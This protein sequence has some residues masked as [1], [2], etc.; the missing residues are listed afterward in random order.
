MSKILIGEEARA[1]L[2]KGANH[3]ADT[4]KVTLGPQGKNVII[5]K[6]GNIHTTKDGV[7][8][9][10]SIYLADNAEN[11]GAQMVKEVASKTGDVAGD[12]TTTSVVLAQ[13]IM[14]QW[15]EM[16]NSGQIVHINKFKKGIE[17]ALKI[18]L[19]TIKEKAVKIESVE[20]LQLIA[21]ISS[22]GDSEIAK[23]VAETIWRIGVDGLITIEDSKNF[24]THVVN[25]DGMQIDRG[26]IHPGFITNHGNLTCELTKP[27]I[28]LTDKKLSFLKDLMPVLKDL[29]A[30][31]SPYKSLLII[32]EDMD[33]EALATLI[34]NNEKGTIPCCVIKRP[35][36]GTLSD[37]IMGDIATLTDGTY[38]SDAYG[39]SMKEANGSTCGK[40]DK[41]IV[42]RN[43]TII[44]GGKGKPV[45]IEKRISEIK[46][47]LSS[48]DNQ[49]TEIFA[50]RRLARITSKVAIFNVAGISEM[51]K[52][53]KKDRIDDAIC[54]AKAALEE[55]YVSGM[56][57]I[58]IEA[59]RNIREYIDN[60][61]DID[62]EEL[63]MQLIE[64]AILVPTCSIY[65]N[66]DVNIDV[67]VI[68][69]FNYNS[70]KSLYNISYVSLKEEGI[71]DP[72]KV[73]RVAIENAISI[74]LLFLSTDG[75]V[76]D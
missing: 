13:A 57:S 3:L 75:I 53:E 69:E 28:V 51:E 68:K 71:I 17:K 5:S 64:N 67:K 15:T 65:R 4:V 60:V 35:E 31:N 48:S 23:L 34:Y 49:T 26:V 2:I 21:E 16:K 66:A 73:T 1:S 10:K 58:Y 62:S 27:L 40:A 59:S 37:F 25:V 61:R 20:E 45:L 74:A 63:G 44:V 42:G 55:G 19:E 54:A 29:Q 43:K 33:G 24:E 6:N 41:V 7:T 39:Y 72:A 14:N 18:V 32:C 12:G 50:K 9:A 70:A 56:G 11:I 46:T 8:V 30:E 52:E 47:Q 22:N 76:I 36:S 38:L